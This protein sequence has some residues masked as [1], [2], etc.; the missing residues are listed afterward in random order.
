MNPHQP[1][2]GT[3][4]L[5]ELGDIE[6]LVRYVDRLCDAEEWDEV[7]AVRALSRK[8]LE[9]GR[10]LWPVAARAEYRL[11]LSA[12]GEWAATV[13]RPGAGRFTL[14]PLPEV[15]ASSH[16]WG[17]LAPHLA[18]T[19]EATVFAFERIALGED[20][21]GEHKRLAGEGFD[22]PLA[23]QPWEP[24]YPAAIYTPD[25]AE[26]PLPPVL[27]NA[28]I[29]CAPGD[30]PA[31]DREV[32]DALAGL[33]TV[34]TT[35]SNGRAEAVAAVGDIGAALAILGLRRAR[36]ARLDSADALARMAWTAASGGAHGRRRGLAAGR[37]DAWWA[38]AALAGLLDEWPVHPDDLGEAATELEWWAWDTGAPDTG[39]SLRLA[40][41]DPV[42]GLSWAVVCADERS[43]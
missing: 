24:V 20:L 10:Q 15:A 34:W 29:D 42:D 21:S 33:A 25:K 9:R 27:T 3:L 32:L 23:L 26:F 17:E 38:L 37:F 39:W 36:V 43:A 8:A 40:V 30:G 12:P 35:E 28:E 14:G 1:S 22:L 31:A 11:A 2:N 19:P 13:L 5:I 18:D 7:E 16:A 41:H 6:E 4:D